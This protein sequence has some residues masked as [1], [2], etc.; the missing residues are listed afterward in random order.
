M[1]KEPQNPA[2]SLTEFVTSKRHEGWEVA[3]IAPCRAHLL[4]MLKRRLSD[5]LLGK[6]YFT[7]WLAR[8][9]YVSTIEAAIKP[10][11]PASSCL[12][13]NGNEAGGALPL[14]SL[15]PVQLLC[16]NSGFAGA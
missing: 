16:A 1:P 2:P 4:L 9:G 3:G 7:G 11:L 8:M 13:R 15:A 12:E 14:Y 10:S 6:R 5:Q